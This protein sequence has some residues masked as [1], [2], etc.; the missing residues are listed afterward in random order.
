MHGIEGA[1]SRAARIS[2]NI[3]LG[4]VHRDGEC[5]AG[6]GRSEVHI[7]QEEPDSAVHRIR[8]KESQR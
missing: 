1:G 7:G 3:K 6:A 8:D 2:G 5:G 4:Y